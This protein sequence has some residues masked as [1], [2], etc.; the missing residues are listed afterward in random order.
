[1]PGKS[2]PL[3]AALPDYTCLA[4]LLSGAHAGCQGGLPVLLYRLQPLFYPAI[5]RCPGGDAGFIPVAAAS[6][7]GQPFSRRRDVAP[8]A[9]RV[10]MMGVLI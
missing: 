9:G 2:G 8:G 6:T 10:S 5:Y 1:M 3:A 4:A 7:P